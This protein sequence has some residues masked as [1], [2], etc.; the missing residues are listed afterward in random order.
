[1][2]SLIVSLVSGIIFAFGLVISGMTNPAKVLGFLDILGQWDYSLAFVMAGAIGFNLIAFKLISKQSKP[3]YADKQDLPTNNNK[4]DKKLL[5]GSA[6]FGIGWGVLGFC[7]GPAIVNL[8]TFS[9]S[10][11]LFI[12]SML[13]GMFIFKITNK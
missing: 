11:L 2:M 12:A 8:V 6:I 13:V 9:S 7:P 3:L 4:L 5:T 10:S 1:M